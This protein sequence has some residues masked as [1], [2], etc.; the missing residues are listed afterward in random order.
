MMT[1]KGNLRRFY[2]SGSTR[3]YSDTTAG[4]VDYTTGKDYNQCIDG[5]LNSKH[6]YND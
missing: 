1:E 3:I 6:Q 2:L 4:T 5:Y